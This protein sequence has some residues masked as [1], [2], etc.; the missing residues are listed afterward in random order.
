MSP[1]TVDRVETDSHADTT[2]AG[3]NCVVLKFTN[4]VIDVFPVCDKLGPMKLVPIAS[5]ATLATDVNGEEVIFIIHESLWFGHQME[6]TLII[7]IIII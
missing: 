1:G 6:H 3:S 5:V 2:C 7:I 4:H